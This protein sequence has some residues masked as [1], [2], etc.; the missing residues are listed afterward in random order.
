MR[1]FAA[2]LHFGRT[3]IAHK[4]KDARV[5]FLDSATFRKEY[6]LWEGSIVLS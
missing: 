3:W 1:N 5:I 2:T 6:I 4:E